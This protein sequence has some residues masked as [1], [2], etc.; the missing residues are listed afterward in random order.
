MDSPPTRLTQRG[1]QF[2]AHALFLEPIDAVNEPVV[3]D[4]FETFV[5]SRDDRLGLTSH[6]LKWRDAFE[7][8][9]RVRARD[10]DEDLPSLLITPAVGLNVI[11]DQ[12]M[13]S[14]ESRAATTSEQGFGVRLDSSSRAQ[15]A[16]HRVELK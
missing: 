11:H 8:W 12:G 10:L 5:Y 3:L 7:R 16:A 4:P 9:I 14:R 1:A 6:P 15:Q 2:V 13:R